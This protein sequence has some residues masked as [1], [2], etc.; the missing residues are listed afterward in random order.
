[1]SSKFCP[2][3]DTEYGCDNWCPL[4]DE[5]TEQC[6][7]FVIAKSLREIEKDVRKK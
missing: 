2:F 5:N 7:I 1:M 3:C 4:Y 6:A